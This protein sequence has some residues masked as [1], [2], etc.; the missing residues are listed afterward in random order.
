MREI[1][2]QYSDLPI[3]WSPPLTHDLLA[4]RLQGADIFVLPSLEED[5]VRSALEA[6]ACGLPVVLTPNTGANDYLRSEEAGEVVP[7]RNAEAIAAAILKLADRLM[8]S[9][10]PPCRHFD[11]WLLSFSRFEDNLLGHLRNIGI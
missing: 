10:R 1:V 3:Q 6:M 5:L 8:N 4:K 7:I 9:R 2:K 11:P